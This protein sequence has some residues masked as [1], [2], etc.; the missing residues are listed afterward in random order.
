MQCLVQGCPQPLYIPPFTILLFFSTDEEPKFTV[1]KCGVNEFLVSLST[2][3]SEEIGVVCIAYY[4]QSDSQNDTCGV[5]KY[6][7][8]WSYEFDLNLPSSSGNV[9]CSFSGCYQVEFEY[10]S[11]LVD[12]ELHCEMWEGWSCIVKTVFIHPLYNQTTLHQLEV[13]VLQ[14]PKAILLD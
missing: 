7:T 1:S 12:G 2:A 3:E 13:Q 4:C 14:Q 8:E 9:T 6:A 10:P 5:Q 11:I